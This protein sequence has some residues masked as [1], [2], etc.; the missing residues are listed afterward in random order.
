M[1]LIQAFD[2]NLVINNDFIYHETMSSFVAGSALLLGLLVPVVVRI[3]MKKRTHVDTAVILVPVSVCVLIIDICAF[4]VQL[5]TVLLAILILFVF[6]TNFRALLRFINGLYVDYYHVPF[7]IV[8]VLSGLAVLFLCFIL[9]WFAPVNDMDIIITVRDRPAYTV[10]RNVY[11]G[12]AY[13]GLRDRE[14]MLEP[15]SAV[16]TVYTPDRDDGTSPVIVCVPDVCVR[17][18]D[19]TPLLKVLASRGY[20]A[21]AADIKTADTALGV[22]NGTWIRPF[23]MRVRRV[24]DAERYKE[25]KAEVNQKKMIE[26]K[27]YIN[28]LKVQYPGRKIVVVADEPYALIYQEKMED[29]ETLFLNMHGLGFLPLTQ[30]LDAFCMMPDVYPYEERRASDS[31]VYKAADYIIGECK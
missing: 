25:Q 26:T 14:S 22:V 11:T 15:T 13:Q 19:Y 5:F 12:T 20:I 17:A 27:A 23:V 24:F 9:F 21:A 28:A 4:G 2:L 6:I 31:M 18:S 8:T 16:A 30:P 1:V 3:F 10:S 29:V 7:V